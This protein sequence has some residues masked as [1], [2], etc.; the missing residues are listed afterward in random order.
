M[1]KFRFRRQGHDP[2]REKLKQDIYA[3]NKGDEAWTQASLACG[4]PSSWKFG[5]WKGTA[6]TLPQRVADPNV[7]ETYKDIFSEMS[8]SVRAASPSELGQSYRRL[9]P[10]LM[11]FQHNSFFSFFFQ[12]V[13]H[14][15]PNQPSSLA[16][17][18]KLCIMAIGTKSGAIK[19]Y[20]S[21][22]GISCLS[23]H[24]VLAEGEEEV[25]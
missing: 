17:D 22:R 24:G 4:E 23:G 9:S 16:F 13:E 1:M 10:A 12:M 8:Q 18:L 20:P 25:P 15:F 3:F 19:M 6:R 7:S 21:C 2:Q 14:G 11:T 5:N